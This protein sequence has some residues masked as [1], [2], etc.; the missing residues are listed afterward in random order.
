MSKQPRNVLKRS[1]APVASLLLAAFAASAS[2]STYT[3][4]NFSDAPDNNPGDDSC[5]STLAGNPCTLRA[6]VMEA[7]AH[8][9]V[10]IIQ[11]SGGTHTLSI[12][13]SNENAALTGDLDVGE[14][15]QIL[16]Q[17]GILTT[18]DGGGIDRIFDVLG[19]TDFTLSGVIVRNGSATDPVAG[20]D[21]HV[22]GGLRLDNTG[23]NLIQFSVIEDNAANAGGG[24][25]ASGSSTLI[26]YSVLRGNHADGN[27][28]ITNPEGSALLAGNGSSLRLENS[29]V[30]GN[31]LLGS[32]VGEIGSLSLENASLQMF[33]STVDG[34]NRSGISAY[35]SDVLL[36]N[37]T[38]TGHGGAG[39]S[40]GQFAGVAVTLY[41]RNSIIAGNAK[42]CSIFLQSGG[43]EDIDGH[44]IDSDGSCGLTVPGNGNQS[45]IP[46]DWMLGPL[47][48]LIDLPARFPHP[49]GPAWNSGSPLD[50]TSGNP[51]ACFRYDQRGVDRSTSGPC[52]VGAV[53]SPH[54]F[55]NGFE[56]III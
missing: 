54:L 46:L 33:S 48:T 37:V 38:L 25:W 13:G 36:N 28:Q 7:N 3:P 17:P 8:P 18:L 22:G 27:V 30:Y 10:D 52:D 49:N 21:A 20:N 41:V 16:S 31:G 15:L 50:P 44:N 51:D 11:L 40:W 5:A 43:V 14:D 45:G 42:D 47:N 53:E 29:S 2:A 55:G 12:T 34:D 32:G 56:N 1:L 35:N 39:L 24:I 26:R 23:S 4:T 6:A 19:T 9:G